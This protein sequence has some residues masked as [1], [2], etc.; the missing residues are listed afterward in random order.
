METR[1]VWV[2]PRGAPGLATEHNLDGGHDEHQDGSMCGGTPASDCQGL[3]IGASAWCV[4]DE[5][6]E[7]LRGLVILGNVMC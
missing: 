4:E 3:I 1:L 6:G 7:C 5:H 2:Y